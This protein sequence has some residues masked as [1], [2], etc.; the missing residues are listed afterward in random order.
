MPQAEQPPRAVLAEADPQHVDVDLVTVQAQG[1]AETAVDQ[2]DAEVAA[3]VAAP[4]GTVEALHDEDELL[5]VLRDRIQPGAVGG[6]VLGLRGGQQLDD[7]ADAP[8]VIKDQPAVVPVLRRVG[9]PVGEVTLEDGRD[10][11]HVVVEVWG[12]G[13][14][15]DERVGDGLGDLGLAA[16]GDGARLVAA[17]GRRDCAHQAPLGA[18]GSLLHHLHLVA[19]G[20]EV[21]LV[22]TQ[23]DR[24]LAAVRVVPAGREGAQREGR[25]GRHHHDVRLFRV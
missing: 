8:V 25:V 21:G 22:C 15:E 24:A 3:P 6:R 5:D 9:E 18:V 23:P 7:A 1:I 20:A 16:A 17:G 13:V 11:V 2:A 4:L 14:A 12:V 10:R 19:V